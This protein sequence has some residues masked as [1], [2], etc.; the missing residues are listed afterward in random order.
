MKS[1]EVSPAGKSGLRDWR[2]GG[3]SAAEARLKRGDL[4]SAAEMAM[5][6]EQLPG[7]VLPELLKC[8]LA[9]LLRGEIKGKRG[10]KP[11]RSGSDR[12]RAEAG[13]ALY[14]RALKAFQFLHARSKRP[15]K[16]RRA[17][18]S[19]PPERAPHERALEYVEK[20]FGGKPRAL[21]EAMSHAGALPNRR[22]PR[23][24]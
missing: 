10:P 16:S 24:R 17:A 18:Q 13:P 23:K 2:P 19:R 4:L 3:V 6:V 11:R 9:R 5:V 8:H 22:P 15:A 12:I 1:V 14:A 7:D 21:Y 20:R